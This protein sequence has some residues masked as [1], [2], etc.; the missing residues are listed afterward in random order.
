M[1]SSSQYPLSLRMSS[2]N[3][4]RGR[5]PQKSPP[6]SPTSSPRV[7]PPDSTIQ[8]TLPYLRD[9]YSSPGDHN[10]ASY[11]RSVFTEY[12]RLHGDMTNHEGDPYEKLNLQKLKDRINLTKMI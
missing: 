1:S 6:N 10:S 11:L 2:L 5:S 3:R 7:R 12:L 8:S 4:L 9:I